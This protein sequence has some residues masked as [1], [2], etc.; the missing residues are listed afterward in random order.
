[1]RETLYEWNDDF[2]VETT[3]AVSVF[4]D[5]LSRPVQ[6]STIPTLFVEWTEIVSFYSEFG[7][8]EDVND[9]LSE[10]SQVVTDAA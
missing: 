9:S 3:I 6:S 7:G 8:R 4:A 10:V 1:M 2:S 5:G